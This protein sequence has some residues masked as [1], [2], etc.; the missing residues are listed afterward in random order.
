MTR[1][2]AKT[3]DQSQSGTKSFWSARLVLSIVLVAAALLF[4]FSNR[5]TAQVAFFG[6]YFTLPMWVWFIVLLTVGI[7]IGSLRPWGRARK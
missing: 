6:L 1:R 4:V 3:T 2:A 7:V 5:D